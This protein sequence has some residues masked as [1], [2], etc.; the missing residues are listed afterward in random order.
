MLERLIHADL[1]QVCACVVRYFGGIKL[2]T[3]GLVR[4]YGGIVQK[5]IDEAPKASEQSVSIYTV[6]YPYELS[7]TFA[8][9]LRSNSEIIDTDYGESVNVLVVVSDP[10]FISQVQA[11]SKGKAQAVFLRNETRLISID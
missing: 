10:D 2:G 4:A 11:A 7:G 3:G 8:G 1:D 6:S 9:W 5:A